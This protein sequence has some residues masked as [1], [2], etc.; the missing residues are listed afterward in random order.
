M[1][2]AIEGYMFAVFSFIEC[3]QP[4]FGVEAQWL[5]SAVN[6]EDWA[7]AVIFVKLVS[8]SIILQELIIRVPSCFEINL[9]V[10]PRHITSYFTGLSRILCLVRKSQH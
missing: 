4:L 3:F 7:D 10:W 5:F 8:F 9:P 6:V 2:F 1:M